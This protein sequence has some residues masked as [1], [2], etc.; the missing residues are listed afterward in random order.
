M[1]CCAQ[2]TGGGVVNQTVV[3]EGDI[4]ASVWNGEV[5]ILLTLAHQEI[6]TRNAPCPLYVMARR[7]AYLPVV[8]ENHNVKEHM[9]QEGVVQSEMWLE[10][11]ETGEV[12]R[13]HRPVGLQHD[14][15]L[16]RASCKK[17]HDVDIDAPWEVVVHFH[18]FP[19]G[20]LLKF[21]E[22]DVVKQFYMNA[23]KEAAY[24]QQGSTKSIMLLSKVEQ[25]QLWEALLEDDF[26]R[27]WE[28][29][30]IVAEG[31]EKVGGVKSIPIRVF[32]PGVPQIQELAPPLSSEGG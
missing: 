22:S 20:I 16:M 1:G 10:C 11:K 7:H 4:R 24:L 17:E 6:R 14:L 31:S 15:Y 19:D 30:N 26:E 21:P 2:F 29:N 25:N 12:L 8:L 3:M 18:N 23:V 32:S 13:W 9:A 28:V 5:P 27:F